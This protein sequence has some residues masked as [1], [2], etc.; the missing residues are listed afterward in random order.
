[1]LTAS[2]GLNAHLATGEEEPP[3]FQGRIIEGVAEH[4][5]FSRNAPV[6]SQAASRP[7]Y[8]TDASDTLVAAQAEIVNQVLNGQDLYAGVIIGC[9]YTVAD[10]LGNLLK[11]FHQLASSRRP[12]RQNHVI[13]SMG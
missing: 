5:I 2:C 12:V 8:S 10:E 3:F 6:Q 11:P 7:A 13:S 1:M 4:S 9:Q